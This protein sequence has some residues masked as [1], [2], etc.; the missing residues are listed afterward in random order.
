M[1]IWFILD[2]ILKKKK[3]RKITRKRKEENILKWKYFMKHFIWLINSVF[4][5]NILCSIKC[6]TTLKFW[7]YFDIICTYVMYV[8]CIYKLFCF[9]VVFQVLKR[10]KKHSPETSSS[11]SPYSD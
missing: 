7:T 3:N 2:T 11:D 5:W 10:Q 6:L 4:T 8:S 9:D 1:A